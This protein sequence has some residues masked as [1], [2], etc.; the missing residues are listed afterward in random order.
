MTPRTDEMGAALGTLRLGQGRPTFS[1]KG[2]Q[3]LLWAH[4]RAGRVKTTVSGIPNRLN[5]CIIFIIC[6]F[7]FRK[8]HEAPEGK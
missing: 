2:P 1:G 3:E 4:S 7:H 8:G 5:Y 6:K